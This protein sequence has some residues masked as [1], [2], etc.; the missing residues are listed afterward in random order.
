MES[1][2]LFSQN[3][4]LSLTVLTLNPEVSATE[5]LLHLFK[6]FIL[7]LMVLMMAT[8]DKNDDF[9]AMAISETFQTKKDSQH[10]FIITAYKVTAQPYKVCKHFPP[11]INPRYT[12]GMKLS[13]CSSLQLLCCYGRSNYFLLIFMDLRAKCCRTGTKNPLLTHTNTVV[14]KR[15]C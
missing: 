4:L 9:S 11:D 6:Q 10:C 13:V 15:K 3:L 1:T 2:L 5:R 14:S 7:N 12:F 8:A